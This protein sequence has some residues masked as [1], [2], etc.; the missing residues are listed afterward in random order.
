MRRH[1]EPH[2]FPTLNELAFLE[3]STGRQTTDG[4]TP[5]NSNYLDPCL[6][7]MATKLP[8][9]NDKFAVTIDGVFTPQECSDL[10]KQSEASPTGYQQA[11]L[12]IGVGG[13]EILAVEK[14]NSDRHIRDD[15]DL[16]KRIFE[17][18]QQHIPAKWRGYSL[19]GLNERL[20]FLRYDPGE[21]CWWWFWPP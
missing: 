15:A 8:F 3:L 12:N 2:P 1:V 14:R 7:T 16:A 4:H 13:T 17:R 10:I 9:L 20:R 11:L 21:L 5:S 18:V 6:H 19:V